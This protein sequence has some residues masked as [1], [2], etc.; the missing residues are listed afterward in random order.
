MRINPE[1]AEQFGINHG[2]WV[3]IESP[4]GRC[5]QRALLTAGI[6]PRV[7]MAEHDWW[8]PER[9]GPEHGAWESNI[10]VLLKVSTMTP[11]W[12]PPLAEVYY[13]AYTGLRMGKVEDGQG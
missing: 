5:K 6:D 9:P 8:F 13:A 3:Y 7:V 10:N 2:D 12:V 1:T 11:G 4:R